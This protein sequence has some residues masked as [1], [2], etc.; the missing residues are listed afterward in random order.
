MYGCVWVCV[1]VSGVSGVSVGRGGRQIEHRPSR[2]WTTA[3][4]CPVG[5]LAR[6]Q[7][8]RAKVRRRRQGEQTREGAASRRGRR[9]VLGSAACYCCCLLLLASWY[10][11]QPSLRRSISLLVLVLVHSAVVPPFPP[12]PL[13]LSLLPGTGSGLDGWQ[14]RETRKERKKR[15]GRSIGCLGLR[16]LLCNDQ[17]PQARGIPA[18]AAVPLSILVLCWVRVRRVSSRP[19]LCVHTTST[20]DRAGPWYP[21]C[22]PCCVSVPCLALA[23]VTN[24]PRRRRAMSACTW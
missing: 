20:T 13:C 10:I 17:E 7:V 9:R 24:P 23:C 2:R 6:K 22:C 21:C 19:P 16:H 15:A 4:N 12:S 18:S 14:H 11:V 8:V 5:L 1:G 3:P